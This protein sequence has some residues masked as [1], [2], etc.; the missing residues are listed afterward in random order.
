M[1]WGC[2]GV[3]YPCKL[4]QVVLELSPLVVVKLSRIADTRMKSWNIFSVVVF[5]D[6][7]FVG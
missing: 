2:L 6:L 5:T 3:G 1:V 7:F 4:E